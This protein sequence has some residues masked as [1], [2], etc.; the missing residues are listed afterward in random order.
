MLW[1]VGICGSETAARSHSLVTVGGGVSKLDDL[2]YASRHTK[3]MQ[4]A[5]CVVAARLSEDPN[6]SVAVLE[7]GPSHFDD[8]VPGTSNPPIITPRQCLIYASCRSSYELDEDFFRRA[9]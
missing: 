5:G 1:S 4:T 7:A 6:I 9:V 8:T 3:C 2:A